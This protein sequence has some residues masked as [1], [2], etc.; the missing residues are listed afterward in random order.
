MKAGKI[1]PRR[2]SLGL[3]FLCNFIVKEWAIAL[4]MNTATRT[5]VLTGEV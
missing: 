5:A 1:I 2:I 4:H 3:L